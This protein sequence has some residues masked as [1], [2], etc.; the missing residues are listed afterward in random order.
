[1]RC[2]YAWFQIE[3]DKLILTVLYVG[4]TYTNSAKFRLAIR[5]IEH[6]RLNLLE[7]ARTRKSHDQL[8][9]SLYTISSPPCT[10]NECS[11]RQGNIA[12]AHHLHVQC[13]HCS[14]S[15]KGDSSMPSV[16]RSHMLYNR[17]CR[18]RGIY[19]RHIWRAVL[20]FQ[21]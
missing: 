18:K 19:N 9:A 1:M 7:L 21:F 15:Q 12:D 6:L 8:S 13:R 16:C 2:N 20:A 3:T 5:K 14:M 11:L 17:S 10:T 4:S